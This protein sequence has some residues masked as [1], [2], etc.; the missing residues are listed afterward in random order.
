MCGAWPTSPGAGCPA[1]SRASFLGP[2]TRL[3]AGG[4]GRCPPSSARF[5]ASAT[6]PRTRWPGCSTSASAWWPPFH[7]TR[8][9]APTTPCVPAVWPPSRSARSSRAAAPSSSSHELMSK[10]L[11]VDDEPDI[12]L[13]L[14]VNL[15]AAGYSTVLAADGETALRRIDEEP[16]DLILL[17]IMMPVMDG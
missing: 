7:P 4:P 6:S 10:V 3:F 8:C 2:P 11:I 17:D 5:S 14:R 9:F 1:T 15:E 12:L 16:P 13:M